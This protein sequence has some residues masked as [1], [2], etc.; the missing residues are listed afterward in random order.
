MRSSSVISVHESVRL[1]IAAVLM[2]ISFSCKKDDAVTNP[3]KTV[4]PPSQLLSAP[5]YLTATAVS[6]SEID[7]QWKDSMNDNAGFIIQATVDTTGVWTVIDTIGKSYRIYH[8]TSL[9][10]NTEYIYRMFAYNRTGFRIHQILHEQ[11]HF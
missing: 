11:R 1:L 6:V 5:Y 8:H 9:L 3:Q 7:L 10:C 2:I 4:I